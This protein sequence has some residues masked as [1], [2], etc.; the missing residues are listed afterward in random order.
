MVL[1]MVSELF[2]DIKDKSKDDDEDKGMNKD[3]DDDW[4]GRMRMRED[5]NQ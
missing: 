5:G 2:H 4:G 1:P 3:D